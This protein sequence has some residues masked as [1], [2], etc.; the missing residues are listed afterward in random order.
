MDPYNPIVAETY[1]KREPWW[2]V[3]SK[4]VMD[5]LLVVVVV[6]LLAVVLLSLERAF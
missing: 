3:A 6:W 4:L 2:A 1:I 5:A